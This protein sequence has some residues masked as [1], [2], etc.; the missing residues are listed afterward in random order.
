MNA[1]KLERLTIL[2]HLREERRKGGLH[3]R[4]VPLAAL[5]PLAEN[6]GYA[7]SVLAELGWIKKT[8]HTYLITALGITALEAEE[9]ED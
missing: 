5:L 8:G 1:D 2:R 6:A 9:T 7:I 4:P 3:P